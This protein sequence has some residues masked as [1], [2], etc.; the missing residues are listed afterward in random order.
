MVDVDGKLCGSQR[1]ELLRAWLLS[2]AD[3]C[4]ERV[5]ELLDQLGEE[6]VDCVDD[7]ELLDLECCLKQVTARKIRRALAKRESG[8]CAAE[9]VV[10]PVRSS[11]P[12]AYTCAALAYALAEES[13]P[14]PLP[15]SRGPPSV[16]RR[17]SEVLTSL[18]KSEEEAAVAAEAA[19]AA[20]ALEESTRPPAL[21]EEE[22]QWLA[23]AA[24]ALSAAKASNSSSPATPTRVRPAAREE[25]LKRRRRLQQEQQLHWSCRQLLLQQQAQAQQ[26]EQAQQLLVQQQQQQAQQAQQLCLSYR[27]HQ[28]QQQVQQQQVQQQQVQQ[29]AQ[30]QVQQQA[31]Q[32][33]SRISAERRLLAYAVD[34]QTDRKPGMHWMQRVEDL[35]RFHAGAE[36]PGQGG[37]LYRQGRT[38]HCH[39]ARITTRTVAAAAVPRSPASAASPFTTSPRMLVPPREYRTPSPQLRGTSAPQRGF[40]ARAA[41]GNAPRLYSTAAPA[42][43]ARWVASVGTPANR[44]AAAAYTSGHSSS[45]APSCSLSVG[46]L[47]S[48]PRTPVCANLECRDVSPADAIRIIEK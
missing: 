47:T 46:E 3:I 2:H 40:N 26:Q 10:S 6:E 16:V 37:Q 21:S 12:L 8:C 33:L 43:I 13:A 19:E 32:Q 44:E 28:A 17:L 20:E 25:E 34:R 9:G 42:I 24:V 5:D 48:A 15:P 14:P 27:Q 38:P 45:L 22:P 7:L 39:G 35:H 18:D 4:C 23:D 36:L 11:G 30:Q 1:R 29:Q 31:Q 41:G